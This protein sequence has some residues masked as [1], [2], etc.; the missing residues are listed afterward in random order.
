MTIELLEGTDLVLVRG[1][2]AATAMA[3]DGTYIPA[4]KY[5]EE[6][7]VPEGTV[8][9]W[10]RRNHIEAISLFGRNYVKKGCVP[11]ARSYKKST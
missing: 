7:N 4:E 5:A 6:M 11:D 8:R 10:K 3:T 2:D 9:V 1:L